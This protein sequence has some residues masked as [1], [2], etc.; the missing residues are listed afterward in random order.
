MK[1]TL[2]LACLMIAVTLQTFA[3]L[4]ALL[5]WQ[6]EPMGNALLNVNFL[7]VSTNNGIY[8]YSGTISYGDGTG[9]ESIP[10][11]TAHNYTTPGTYTVKLKVEIS[12]STNPTNI[13]HDSVTQLVTVAYAPCGATVAKQ[14]NGN[15][16]YTFTA[17][18]P[19]NT[20]GISY[21]WDFGDNTTGSGN[22]VTHTYTT[23]GWYLASLTSTANGCTYINDSTVV[24]YYTPPVM[25]PCDSLVAS[26]TS[27]S[28]G[29]NVGFSNTSTS[30]ST[31]LALNVISVAD[32]YFGDGSSQIATPYGNHT[33][34]ATGTYNVT[35][36]NHWQDS[37]TA[38]LYCTDTFVSQIVLNN[39]VGNDFIA[40]Y[41]YWDSLSTNLSFPDTFKV[42]LIQHD[43][44]ANTLTAVDSQYLVLSQFFQFNNEPAGAYLIKATALG[45]TSGTAG[46]LP[47]YHIS[48]AYWNTA[49]T[50]HYT[51]GS[52]YGND[53]FILNGTATSGPGFI[54]GNISMGAGKGT[55]TGVPNLLV[56]LRGANNQLIA[57]TLTNAD[58]DYS[59]SNIATGT[60]SIYPES[61]NYT[62]T[63]YNAVAVTSG[64]T[65]VSAIDFEQKG[66][67]IYPKGTEGIANVTKN[68]GLN[69][70]PN[71]SKD[72]LFIECK[73]AQFNHLNVINTL[74]QVVKQSTLKTGIN[75]IGLSDMNAGVY[76][77]LIS[78]PKDSRVMK[79]TKN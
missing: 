37:T 74:G 64:M 5:N 73:N 28:N 2:L 68:D 53:I 44:I 24:Y 41:I 40:G 34:A 69:I 20:P 35:M 57:A 36:V 48:S 15:G 11:M 50:I 30:N 13:L 25:P 21:A 60:Y 65:H 77:L 23:G 17:T 67:L 14:D 12:D 43:T 70:Y 63:P 32:W 8:V 78:G 66:L 61:M 18:N 22:P 19:A 51:G 7:N 29:L 46:F 52:S 47:T 62:T 76:Y 55:G 1:K 59:F 4:H 71:P 79:I 31:L 45:Q 58:G 10:Y 54:G 49:T 72:Q 42:W 33:Y 38:Q 26:F 56:Y 39:P 6:A 16:S 75:T 27:S 3:Q 9:T